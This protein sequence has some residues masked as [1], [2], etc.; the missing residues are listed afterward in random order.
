MGRRVAQAVLILLLGVAPLVLL[1]GGLRL[2]GWPT[3]RV[4]TFGKLLN[5]DLESWN[6]SV[7]MFHPSVRSRVMWPVELA[8]GVRINSL[9]LR[10]RDIERKPPPGRT[11]VLAL[12]DSMT[13]GFY[14]EEEHTW[15]VRL[16]ARLRE[17]GADV[18]VVNAGVGGWSIDSQTQFALERGLELEPDLV[19]V[20][21]C[22]N[23]PTDLVRHAGLY[24]SVKRSLG[25]PRGRLSALVYATAAY[26]LYLTFQVRWKAFRESRGPR[27]T[28][29]TGHDL[30][31][32]QLEQAWRTYAE[33]VDR[34][35]AA[36]EQRGIPLTLV[37]L[38]NPED[39]GVADANA[40]VPM[41][42]RLRA[43][44]VE[45]GIGFVSPLA[46]FRADPV[47]A[48]HHMPLD[49]HLGVEGARRV[50][51]VLAEALAPRPV[52]AGATAPARR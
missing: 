14:L 39:V 41:E 50:A 25:S 52:S 32:E 51:V 29:G 19:L 7:G 49:P 3:G 46:A 34:L 16:E 42:A 8:Y 12:G 22:V 18:E 44:A 38:P 9:G 11:R 48:L 47:P 2:A 23:D 10:G 37:Y 27:E 17:L 28:P 36:L 35:H 30:P 20:G 40:P 43:I 21:F 15:P 4:R 33:W 1:E 13:F 31:P 45:R 26:E 6:A 24:E 5:F